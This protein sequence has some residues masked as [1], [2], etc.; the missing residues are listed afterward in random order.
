[1]GNMYVRSALVVFG[2][3]IVQTVFVSTL[4]ID[5]IVPDLLLIWVVYFALVRGQLQ[6]TVAGFAVGLIQDL[7]TTQ[8]FG[9]AALAKTIAGFVGGYFFNDN[10]TELT[11]GTYRFVVIV[12]ICSMVHNLIYFGIF[13]QGQSPVLLRLLQFS[14]TTTLYTGAVSALP[15]FGFSRK[16][17]TI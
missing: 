16:F 8:F 1:M 6:A 7:V 11:L 15:M 2:L 10:K 14:I 9:L 17:Q 13:F 3:L 5:G 12:F 4:A